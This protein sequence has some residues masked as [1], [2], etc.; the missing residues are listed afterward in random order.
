MQNGP[1]LWISLFLNPDIFKFNPW[2]A[3]GRAPVF[4]PCGKAGVSDHQA[5]NAGAYNT[6]EFAKQGDL[7][8]KVLPARPVS[9]DHNHTTKDDDMAL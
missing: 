7:G 9:Y 8:S 3:P 4:D 6:T 2:R 5:F 1:M